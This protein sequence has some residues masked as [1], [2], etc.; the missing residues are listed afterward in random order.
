[1]EVIIGDENIRER[2][3]IYL[4]NRKQTSFLILLKSDNNNKKRW[5]T[6]NNQT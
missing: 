6:S 4:L 3:L 2:Y 1:M 5:R